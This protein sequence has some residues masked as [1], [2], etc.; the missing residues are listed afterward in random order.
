MAQNMP[1]VSDKHGPS[2]LCPT[3]WA[4]THWRVI[5][6]PT[7]LSL[8][9]CKVVVSGVLLGPAHAQPAV[10]MDHEGLA[11]SPLHRTTWF[12]SNEAWKWVQRLNSTVKESVVGCVKWE[13]RPG[14]AFPSVTVSKTR[15]SPAARREP[16]ILLRE[17]T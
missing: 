14:E 7:C 11:V 16:P 4:R 10:A 5:P 9:V 1:P 13:V 2:S 6:A 3:R 8:L 15:L 17:P 12:L